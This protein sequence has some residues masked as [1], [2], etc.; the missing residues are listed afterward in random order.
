V[1][2]PDTSHT[3]TQI[4]T[5]TS[6]IEVRRACLWLNENI[7]VNKKQIKWNLWR[8]RGIIQI[9]DILTEN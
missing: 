3:F 6:A 1:P 4:F 9:H 2:T 7:K 5:L 8:D